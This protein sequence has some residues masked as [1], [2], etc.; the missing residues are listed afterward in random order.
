[1]QCIVLGKS[2]VEALLERAGPCI[3][4]WLRVNGAVN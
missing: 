3:D 1:M 4:P 2:I